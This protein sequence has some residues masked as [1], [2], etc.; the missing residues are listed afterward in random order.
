MT[1]KTNNTE[2]DDDTYTYRLQV[3]GFLTMAVLILAYG[4][5]MIWQNK[6]GWPST[7]TADWGTFGDFIGG[8]AN[9]VIALLALLGLIRT[10]KLQQE[11][12]RKTTK[13]LNDQLDIA[14]LDRY[15][16]NLTQIMPIILERI[17]TLSQQHVSLYYEPEPPTRVPSVIVFPD[18]GEV[19][20][21]ISDIVRDSKAIN[22]SD[23]YNKFKQLT[24]S[25]ELN[26]EGTRSQNPF[27]DLQTEINRA[28]RL[29]AIT[30]EDH[31]HDSMPYMLLH[32]E[33]R[34]Y[35]RMFRKLGCDLHSIF[36]SE[37]R[38]PEEL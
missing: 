14:K 37:P 22:N 5:W 7:N 26:P 19:E 32:E 4:C 18:S 8:V 16:N 23:P 2:L 38:V 6:T 20:V 33:I 3:I 11:E 24:Q 12:F 36:T 13:A 9:P 30:H 29:L 15:E 34:Q 1:D 17:G 21:S 25:L 31:R 35:I 28:G 10:I 27:I